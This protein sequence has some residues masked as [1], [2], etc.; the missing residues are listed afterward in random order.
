MLSHRQDIVTLVPN[1]IAIELGVAEGVMS[2]RML[3]TGLSYLF[4]VDMY[5][6][7]GHN[8][9]QYK[10]ALE[11]LMPY[12]ERNS[13]LKMKFNEALSLFPDEY[14]DL[15]YVDGYAHG[16]QEN[17]QTLRDWYP[18]CKPGGIFAG[19][20]YDSIWPKVIKEVDAFCK[21]RKLE[22]NVIQCRDTDVWSRSPTWF[23]RKPI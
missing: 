12:K 23:T 22:L 14:F 6:D 19:D 16:G 9:N 15:I 10:R 8:I 3:Q 21:E 2:E 17:G 11:R 20:D 7:R 1:G 13:I 4:S 18:K 5:A